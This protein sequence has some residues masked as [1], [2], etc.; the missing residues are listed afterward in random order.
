MTIETETMG[1]AVV[2]LLSESYWP[3]DRAE[4]VE[5]ITVGGRLRQA[6]ADAP[7][8]LAL[9]DGCPDPA[10][11]R[12]WTYAEL[13][14]ASEQVARSLLTRF[15]PGERLLVLA[16]NSPEWVLLQMGAA[17]AGLVLAC[18]NPAYRDREIDYV[19]RRSRAAGVVLADEYRGHDLLATVQ[20]LSA[21][22]PQLRT[23][24]RFSRWD[25]LLRDGDPATALPL[26]DPDDAAQIQYTGGT[27]GFPKGVLLH[28]R[29][30]C[31]APNFVLT[32]AG[33][34]VG[35]TWVNTMP[36]FH[37]GGCVTTGLGILARRGTHV[38][39]REFDPG[40][41]LELFE[42]RRGN[43]SLL[44]P[45]MLIRVLDQ[46]GFARRDVSSVHTLVSGA[47]PVPAE[48][49]RRTKRAFDCQFT[50][51]FGQTEVSGVVTTT[52]TD[53]TPEDQAETI[54][55]A[56]KQ[57]E[58]KIADPSDG[59]VLP[60]GGEGEICGRGYQMMIGYLDDPDAT[61]KTLRPDGWLHTGDVGS[62]DER[63]YVRITGR[64]KE[65]IIR[66][67]ENISPREVEDVLF[68]RP[69]VAEIVV[70][71]I[72]DEEWGEQVAAVI[73]PAAGEPRPSA[74]ELREHCR[75]QIARFKVPALWFFLD[76]Y[77]TTPAGKI[78]KFVLRD[79]ILA[80]ALVPEQL[81]ASVPAA[82][83]ET[84]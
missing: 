53:D 36:L 47:A 1:D 23:I 49:I 51:I 30:I 25:E 62:M 65:M 64:L 22:L 8:R 38:V 15:S 11:R 4:P 41:V 79:Q 82:T 24:L 61:A 21:E 68:D 5:E 33:M 77:P 9:V 29:G 80:G 58:L 56:V 48:L 46:P 35:D 72:P 34:Q 83:E 10:A 19:L 6:A 16:P 67:G 14:T 43:M 39:V 69:E 59:H 84:S 71:G 13:L 17:M 66:G 52:R 12:T 27:T 32:N 31:N 45:T 7:D 63:G 37:V 54:G 18:A 42:S 20:R 2:E 40:V 57:V 44:V 75:R 76:S 81:P 26:V 55:R 78:Q 70:L 28:H 74:A 73:R 3:A 60:I 50:N